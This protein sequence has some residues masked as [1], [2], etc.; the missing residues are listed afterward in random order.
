MD[1][2]SF[3]YVYKLFIQKNLRISKL[4]RIHNGPLA[5]CHLPTDR[6]IIFPIAD[7]YA[8]WEYLLRFFLSQSRPSWLSSKEGALLLLSSFIPLCRAPVV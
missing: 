6:P 8:C 1:H 2:K 3:I 7:R 4:N 5:C